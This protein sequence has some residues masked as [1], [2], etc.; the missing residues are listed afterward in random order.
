MAY[1]PRNFRPFFGYHLAVEWSKT[2]V[3]CFCQITAMRI[4]TERSSPS[5]FWMTFGPEIALNSTLSNGPKP[6]TQRQK[7]RMRK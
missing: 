2:P 1:G 4:R 5:S 7:T 6:P 3:T